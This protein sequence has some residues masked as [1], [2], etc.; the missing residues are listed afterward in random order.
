M[1]CLDVCRKGFRKKVLGKEQSEMHMAVVNI[2]SR[3]LYF[4]CV[5]ETMYSI[6]DLYLKTKQN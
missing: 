6:L 3:D 5:F 4:L 1:M 2:V